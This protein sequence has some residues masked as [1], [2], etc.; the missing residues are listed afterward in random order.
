MWGRGH[1]LP[2]SCQLTIVPLDGLVLGVVVEAVAVAGSAAMLVGRRNSLMSEFRSLR[3]LHGLGAVA[4]RR[5]EARVA[6]GSA[7]PE[8][9]ARD[10]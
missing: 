10:G 1:V 6:R 7:G 9:H 4:G 2:A 8:W 5:C 3:L